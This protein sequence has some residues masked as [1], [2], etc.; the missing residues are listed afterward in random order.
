MLIWTYVYVSVH[1]HLHFCA[2]AG[3]EAQRVGMTSVFQGIGNTLYCTCFTEHRHHE[4]F[5][6]GCPGQSYQ[7]NMW[8][9]N[10]VSKSKDINHIF[11]KNPFQLEA[12]E[13]VYL[14]LKTELMNFRPPCLT[15]SWT[16]GKFSALLRVLKCP[17]GD[18]HIPCTFSPF[19]LCSSLILTNR[20]LLLFLL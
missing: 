13:W 2:G 5:R 17:K 20:C 9:W 4:N 8:Y 12:H 10:G 11:F 15:H 6:D 3:W 7:Q 19:V 1:A 16:P 18:A 14:L